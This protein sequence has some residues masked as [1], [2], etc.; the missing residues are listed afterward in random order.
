MYSVEFPQAKVYVKQ[1]DRSKT[2]SAFSPSTTFKH[3]G[4]S[5]VLAV[6]V[7]I[8]SQIDGTNVE[9]LNHFNF[10]GITVY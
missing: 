5:I 2:C 7:H 1:V 6:F 10:L 3:H 4:H 9:C 8:V